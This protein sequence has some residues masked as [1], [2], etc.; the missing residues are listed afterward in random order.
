MTTILQVADSVVARING[1]ALSREVAAERLYVP[2]FELTE[3]KT[4]RVSVVPSELKIGPHDRTTSRYHAKVDVAVQ[5]KFEAGSN[6]EIDPLVS[7]SEE[8]A[9]LFRLQRLPSLP[10]ARCTEV[11]IPVLY[12]AES[13]EQ[14]R[15]FTSVMTL[16]FMFV[17]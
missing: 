12:S 15:L 6:A 13:W 10:A 9:D 17:K 4:L 5:Q 16:T 11:E 7:L 1:A 14:M 3:M 8:I 2:N